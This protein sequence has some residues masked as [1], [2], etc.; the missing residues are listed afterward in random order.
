[1]GMS[2]F[3]RDAETAVSL[4]VSLHYLASHDNWKIELGGWKLILAVPQPA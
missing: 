2:Y 3:C 4:S 1:M